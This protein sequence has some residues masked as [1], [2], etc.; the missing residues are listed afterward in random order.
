MFYSTGDTYISSILQACLNKIL[1]YIDIFPKLDF[2]VKFKL[3]PLIWINN[4]KCTAHLM[5]WYYVCEE[6]T[7]QQCES[8][9]ASD[10]ALESGTFCSA[11]HKIYGGKAT[12]TLHLL[13]GICK[14]K[15]LH[16]ACTA[17]GWLFWL[18]YSWAVSAC[19]VS[20]RSH[21]DWELFKKKTCYFSCVV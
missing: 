3:Q 11:S 8:L 20:W 19:P 17:S 12:C 7:L 2:M 21:T 6:T 13:M 16:Q 4:V 10:L 14:P 1:L 9:K 5:I 15:F 18:W